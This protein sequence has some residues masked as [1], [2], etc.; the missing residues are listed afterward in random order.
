M[1]CGF[2]AESR[3][4]LQEALEREFTA[5]C[6]NPI[7]PIARAV[8]RAKQLPDLLHATARAQQ[9]CFLLDASV[10]AWKLLQELLAFKEPRKQKQR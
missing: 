8:I 2:N 3:S 1:L 6:M 4:I 7:P 10:E 9:S 5:D